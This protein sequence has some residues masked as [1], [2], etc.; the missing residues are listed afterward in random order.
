MRAFAAHIVYLDESG[1]TVAA[2]GPDSYPVFVLA[3]ILVGK[4]VY[5]REVV[6][7]LQLIK[8]RHFGQDQIIFHERDIRRQS[9]VFAIFQRDLKSREEFLSDVQSFIETAKFE[10]IAAIIAKDGTENLTEPLDAYEIALSMVMSAVSVKLEV[11]DEQNKL[12]HVVAE[13]RGRIEDQA[14]ELAFR[15]IGKGEA[16]GEHPVMVSTSKFGWEIIFADKR[17]NSSGLQISDLLARPIGL[18]EVRPGQRNRAFQAI[19]AKSG[20]V[21][22]TLSRKA[23]GPPTNASSPTPTEKLQST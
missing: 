21:I 15:R 3:A 5:D 10:I 20:T 4:D 1:T 16:I 8:F 6:P 2:K 19:R 12:V 13:S 14:L 22:T 17:S 11:M 7:E 23:L 9:G 18:S